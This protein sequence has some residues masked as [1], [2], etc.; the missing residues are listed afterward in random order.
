[1][2]NL[3]KLVSKYK[4]KINV[5][6]G[7][8]KRY[9]HIGFICGLI[10]TLFCGIT[11]AQEKGEWHCFHGLSRDNKSAETG[12]LK[13]W[14]E[15]GP[16]LLWTITDLGKGYSSVS[17]AEGYLYTAGVIGKQTVVFAFDMNGKLVWKKSNGQAWETTMSHARAYT[18]SRSTPTYDDGLVYHL[19]DLGR[20]A[21][22]NYRTGEEI[23]LPTDTNVR[24][25]TNSD[26]EAYLDGWTFWTGVDRMNSQR[27]CEVVYDHEKGSNVVEFSRTGGASPIPET[28]PMTLPTSS[29]V[30]SS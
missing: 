10:G 16:E 5:L 7:T 30:T 17:I 25:P 3:A 27:Y 29:V 6:S 26:F 21:T 12:L 2:K 1:M 19:S 4:N 22:F 28:T 9:I 13:K 20:L 8:W 23:K 11:L 24:F 15:T 14:P 18:G